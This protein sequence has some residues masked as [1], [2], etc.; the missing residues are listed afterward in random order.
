MSKIASKIIALAATL[1]LLVGFVFA[2]AYMQIVRAAVESADKTMSEV[3][4]TNVTNRVKYGETFNVTQGSGTVTVKNPGGE[5]VTPDEN[6]NVTANQVGIYEVT[7]SYSGTGDYGDYAG[8]TYNVEV[9]MDY[10]Y[11]LVVEGNG[12][13][14]PTYWGTDSAPFTLPT[15]TLYYLDE[16]TDTWFPDPDSADKVFVRVT[17]PNGTVTRYTKAQLE[18]DA[19]QTVTTAAEGMY[20]FTYYSMQR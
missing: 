13:G 8:Y 15:A 14:I 6:G 10:E 4:K 18:A 3:V 20:F 19:G 1:A 9:Y 17:E 12:A 2:G 7:Y 16:D 5:Y 11:K